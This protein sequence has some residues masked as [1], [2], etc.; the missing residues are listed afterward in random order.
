MIWTYRTTV[1]DIT[2]IYAD[3]EDDV[4]ELPVWCEGRGVMP[5][6][7]CH[8]IGSSNKYMM[9]SSKQWIRQEASNEE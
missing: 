4:P 7:V 3:S 2:T 5:G 9:N 6:S 8:V 1:E